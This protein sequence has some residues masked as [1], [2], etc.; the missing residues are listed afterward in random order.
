MSNCREMDLDKLDTTNTLDLKD[1]FAG[2]NLLNKVTLGKKISFK[3]KS[4]FIDLSAILP[5]EYWQKEGSEKIKNTD[6]RDSYNSSL[7]GTY[8][9]KDIAVVLYSNGDLVFQNNFDVNFSKSR[10]NSFNYGI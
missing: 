9:R 8:T 2:C 6:L 1:M 4:K 10:T 5:D 7:S 3:G